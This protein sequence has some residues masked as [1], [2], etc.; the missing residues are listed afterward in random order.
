MVL[1]TEGLLG[2]LTKLGNTEM[3]GSLKGNCKLVL[4]MLHEVHEEGLGENPAK[5]QYLRV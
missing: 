5:C 1:A 2:P 4:D 3:A